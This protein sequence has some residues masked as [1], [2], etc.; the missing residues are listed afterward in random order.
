MFP[1]IASS[2]SSTPVLPLALACKPN[3]SICS[4]N[5]TENNI[6]AFSSNILEYPQGPMCTFCGKIFANTMVL[7]QH[8]RMHTNERPYKCELCQKSFT[9]MCNLKHHRLTHT[10]ERPF[11]CQIC[12][13]SFTQ[14]GNL[15][16]HER[17]HTGERPF[18]CQ[19]CQKSFKQMVH[20]KQHTQKK[21]H[22][23]K[24]PFI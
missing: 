10:G 8:I 13:K 20:L 17:T 2:N 23:D 18:V 16:Q 1:A 9:Q 3:S 24:R 22:G 4:K 11:V 14:L 12:Q 15:Q 19:I 5:Y 7:T 6:Q 21:H